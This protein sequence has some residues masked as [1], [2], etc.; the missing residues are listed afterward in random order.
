[1][2]RKPE[3]VVEEIKSVDSKIDI[4]EKKISIY[5]RKRKYFMVV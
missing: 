3:V 5:D 2:I 1:L 4:K